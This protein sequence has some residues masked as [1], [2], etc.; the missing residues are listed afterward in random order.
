VHEP[1]SSDVHIMETTLTTGS[2]GTEY[3]FLFIGRKRFINLND[4]IIFSVPPNLTTDE[5]RITLLSKIQLGLVPY[6][7]KTAYANSLSLS[8]QDRGVSAKESKDPWKSWIFEL[9]CLGSLSNRQYAKNYL[10]SAGLNISKINPKMK[11][12]S[13]SYLKYGESRS[14]IPINDSV[15]YT[16]NY[17]D[18]S[19]YSHN[20]LVKSLGAHFGIGMLAGFKKDPFTNYK[21]QMKIGPAIEYNLFKYSDFS[22]KQL[23]FLYSM[24]Y[25]HN[26]YIETTIYNKTKDYLFTQNLNII[27]ELNKSW[28][29]F[30]ASVYV[31]NYLN[32]FSRFS[33]GVYTLNSFRIGRGLSFNISCGL[34]MCRD[35]ISLRKGMASP[36]DVMT[37]QREMESNYNYSVSF[38]FTYRFGSKFNN[39]VNPRFGY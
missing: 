24:V 9:N 12:E 27:F 2:G 20:L 8:V 34:N 3:N 7:M 4:T 18:R 6:L 21:F 31:S 13:E 32:D 1:A 28:G 29:S 30:N 11:F 26:N 14:T 36:A 15:K 25:E 17:Y 33:L 37:Y 39:A 35:Q 22:Y 38:G 23:R 19:I 5:I 10:V 16:L